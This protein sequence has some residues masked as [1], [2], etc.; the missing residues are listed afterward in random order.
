M[1]RSI[2]TG[3]SEPDRRRTAKTAYA[4][5]ISSVPRMRSA[6]AHSPLEKKNEPDAD[7]TSSAIGWRNDGTLTVTLAGGRVEEI[8]RLLIMLQRDG[9][10]VTAV[11]QTSPDGRATADI[12]IRATP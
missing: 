4:G 6:Q 5:R 8:N 3:A 11:P 2:A 9:Y 10:R 7:F 12:T 1:S